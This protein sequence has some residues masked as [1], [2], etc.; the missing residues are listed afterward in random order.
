M[1]G[2]RHCRYVFSS[3]V[4]DRIASWKVE[5]EMTDTDKLKRLAG[6]LKAAHEYDKRYYEPNRLTKKAYEAIL[7]LIAENERLKEEK[8]GLYMQFEAVTQNCFRF[9]AQRDEAVALLRKLN[10]ASRPE[11]GAFLARIDAAE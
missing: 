2:D 9:L 4:L 10:F 1:N 8:E 7:A 11:V 3:R 5:Q 6:E